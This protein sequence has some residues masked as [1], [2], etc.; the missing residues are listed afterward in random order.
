MIAR[1]IIIA[2]V[3]IVTPNLH[4]VLQ[5]SS[6]MSH[7][8]LVYILV[9]LPVQHRD[10]PPQPQQEEHRQEEEEEEQHQEQQIRQGEQ[11][12]QVQESTKPQELVRGKKIRQQPSCILQQPHGQ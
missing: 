1:N 8:V 4:L 11:Q 5:P 9:R 3:T 6:L 7:H 12:R 10:H 2:M